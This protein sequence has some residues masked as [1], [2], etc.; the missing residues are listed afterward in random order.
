ME[1]TFGAQ[2]QLCCR[3]HLFSA[4]GPN[5]AGDVNVKLVHRMENGLDLANFDN[6]ASQL[7]GDVGQHLAAVVTRA[8][9]HVLQVLNTRVDANTEFTTLYHR[10]RAWVDGGL[11]AEW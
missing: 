3:I 6:P 9:Q 1:H 4:Q 2:A 5:L 10:V 8:V 11:I 7:E